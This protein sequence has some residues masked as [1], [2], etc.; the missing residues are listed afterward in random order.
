[1]RLKKSRRKHTPLYENEQIDREII[2]WRLLLPILF[3]EKLNPGKCKV[4]TFSAN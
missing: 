4:K 3:Q 1:M 2:Q